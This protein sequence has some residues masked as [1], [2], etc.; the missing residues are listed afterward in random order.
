MKRGVKTSEF[1]VVS[2]TVLGIF[3]TALAGITAP[4]VAPAAAVVAAAYAISRGMA[5]R[6]SRDTHDSLFPPPQQTAT[7]E[8]P[9]P[10]E[11]TGTKIM[12]APPSSKR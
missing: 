12:G 1:W 8:E 3:G 4:W 6:G 7:S 9:T 11:R 5:K 2:S 10:V